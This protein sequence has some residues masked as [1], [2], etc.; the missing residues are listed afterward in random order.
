MEPDFA[1]RKEYF[2]K[3]AGS[4][5]PSIT[6]LQSGGEK[7]RRGG[8]ARWTWKKKQGKRAKSG[9][10]VDQHKNSTSPVAHEGGE[11]MAL[12]SRGG[13]PARGERKTPQPIVHFEKRTV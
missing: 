3:G 10:T 1:F 2:W 8:E 11:R 7:E 6:I 9:K 5:A 13:G 4:T 12:L